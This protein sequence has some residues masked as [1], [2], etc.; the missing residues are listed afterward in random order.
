MAWRRLDDQVLSSPF[1]GNNEPDT[2]RL[3]RHRYAAHCQWL[4]DVFLRGNSGLL[5]QVP[6]GPRGN[7]RP[8]LVHSASTI[9]RPG[10]HR[11]RRRTCM[12]ALPRLGHVGP[13]DLYV[14]ATSRM[15]GTTVR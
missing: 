2:E 4:D 14:R 6:E 3:A 13:D 11:R 10:D 15:G 5:E 7:W 1:H 9:R 8:V 12:A